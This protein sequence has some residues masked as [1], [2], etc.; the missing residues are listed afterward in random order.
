MGTAPMAVCSWISQ[1]TSMGRRSRKAQTGM[2]VPGMAL[3]SGSTRLGRRSRCTPRGCSDEAVLYGSWV[4]DSTVNL[5]GTTSESELSNGDHGGTVF[6]LTQSGQIT[7]LH[8]FFGRRGAKPSGDMT[9]FD[10]NK[11]EADL[12][13]DSS[14]NL[15]GTTY[16]GGLYGLGRR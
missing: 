9:C 15:F 14:G 6:K 7:V 10:G 13:L 11:P 5:Y 2:A 1:V 16:S 8:S 4:M 3:C 12:T